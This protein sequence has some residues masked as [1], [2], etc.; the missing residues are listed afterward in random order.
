M[1]QVEGRTRRGPSREPNLASTDRSSGRGT[2]TQGEGGQKASTPLVGRV[3]DVRRRPS[4]FQRIAREPLLALAKSKRILRGRRARSVTRPSET[5]L[6]APCTYGRANCRKGD[7]EA[8]SSRKRGMMPLCAVSS[9]RPLLSR[10]KL[11]SVCRTW[12][13]QLCFQTAS[14]GRYVLAKVERRTWLQTSVSWAPARYRPSSSTRT[15]IALTFCRTSRIAGLV[16][17]CLMERRRTIRWV[18]CKPSH[19]DTRPAGAQ[20]NTSVLKCA[21]SGQVEQTDAL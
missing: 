19:A 3:K 20:S 16:D 5:Q 11:K 14:A 4:V 1:R 7:R 12:G 9:C 10:H 2:L 18:G 6:D 21:C 8:T 15:S 17:R 13:G